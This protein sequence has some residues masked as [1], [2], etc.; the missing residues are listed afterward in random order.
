MLGDSTHPP[1]SIWAADLVHVGD[2]LLHLRSPIQALV[3][4]RS[5]TRGRLVCSA[6][7]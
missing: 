7:S 5:V 2:L 4:L 3:A 1:R 6:T